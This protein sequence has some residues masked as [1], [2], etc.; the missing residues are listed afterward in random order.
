MLGNG[1]I[2]QITLHPQRVVSLV[3]SL[4]ES[5]FDLGLGSALVGV[6]DY[7]VRP[8]TKLGHLPRI[9]GTKNP[10][11]NDILALRP[12][13]VLANQEENP[14][15]VIESLQAAGI[16][17][18]VT[19]PK[20][21][22][23]AIEVLYHLG[24]FFRS[25]SAY[26]IVKTLEQSLEWAQL[27]YRTRTSYFCPI[28]HET[29]D[30]QPWWM[31]FNRHTYPHDLLSI[32]GGENVFADRERRYPLSADLAPAESAPANP[33]PAD[34]PAPESDSNPARDTRY[35][36]LPL[37]E[38]RAANPDLIIL[39]NEPYLFTEEHRQQLRAL[40]PETPAVQNDRI[41]LVDGS[42]LTW[43]GTRLARAIQELPGF[44]GG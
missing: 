43:H 29:T 32:F 15:P 20:T 38:I 34:E 41:V 14:R 8:D 3:P 25:Q 23:E 26:L 24:E 1:H 18:W 6:T 16:S 21:V 17:V 13:L 30:N 4:T 36:R 39:P 31:T 10:R 40:L 27:A 35:P 7:C 5:M 22:H 28:W 44:F 9:G 37:E 19:F 12:D 33:T 2:A 42:L 11:V